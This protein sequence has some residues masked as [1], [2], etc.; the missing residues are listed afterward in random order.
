MESVTETQ[1]R[2]AAEKTVYKHKANHNL[3]CVRAPV[4]V[5]TSAKFNFHCFS[6]NFM[7]VYCCALLRPSLLRISCSFTSNDDELTAFTRVRAPYLTWPRFVRRHLFAIFIL[8]RCSP[9]ILS[10]ARPPPTHPDRRPNAFVGCELHCA[11]AQACLVS[12]SAAKT[13]TVHSAPLEALAK[14]K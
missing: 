10:L 13:P 6:F 12:A 8:V 7:C 5:R 2:Q 9:R 1:E 4:D 3:Y 14:M 11:V